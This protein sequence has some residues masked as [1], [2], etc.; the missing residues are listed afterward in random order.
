MKNN[1]PGEGS[2]LEPPQIAGTA[3]TPWGQE[4]CN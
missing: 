3:A 2:S 4:Y 1:M